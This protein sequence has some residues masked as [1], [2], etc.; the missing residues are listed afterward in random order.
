MIRGQTGYT[1][2]CAWCPRDVYPDDF[3]TA[4]RW[5]RFSGVCVFCLGELG[6]GE[7]RALRL[8]R[9]DRGQR[10]VPSRVLVGRLASFFEGTALDRD[11]L[12]WRAVRFEGWPVRNHPAALRELRAELQRARARGGVLK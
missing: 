11:R 1:G 9:G 5:W 3:Y 2:P 12:R 8:L 10:P 7:R 6:D 4:S